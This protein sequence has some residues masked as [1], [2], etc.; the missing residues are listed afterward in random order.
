MKLSAEAPAANCG[1]RFGIKKRG[2]GARNPPRPAAAP[3]KTIPKQKEHG[4]TVL[5]AFYS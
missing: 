5:F 4:K 3:S 2:G 1:G